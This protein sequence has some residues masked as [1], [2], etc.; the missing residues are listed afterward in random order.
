MTCFHWY[1]IHDFIYFINMFNVRNEVKM[2]ELLI[3]MSWQNITNISKIL[4]VY[5]ILIY[6]IESY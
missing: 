4:K 5:L 6:V 3:M 2:Y 1:K